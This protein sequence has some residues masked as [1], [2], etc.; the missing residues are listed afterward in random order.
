MDHFNVQNCARQWG[1]ES[2]NP[3]ITHHGSRDD[4]RRVEVSGAVRANDVYGTGVR[5]WGLQHR[6]G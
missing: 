6:H 5:D 1:G 2:E 3:W 4:L